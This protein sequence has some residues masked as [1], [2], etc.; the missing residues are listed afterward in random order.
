MF[1]WEKFLY[2]VSQGNAK[3]A[4]KKL[5]PFIFHSLQKFI[6]YW[7]SLFGQGTIML[8]WDYKRRKTGNLPYNH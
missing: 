6:F 1:A 2:F 8:M 5:R 4:R 3:Y 7:L